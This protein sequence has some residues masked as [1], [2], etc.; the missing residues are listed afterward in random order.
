MTKTWTP[1]RIRAL[2]VITDLVTAGRIL[3]LSRNVAYHLARTGTFPV[4]V[5]QTGRFYRVHTS[6]LLTHLGYAPEP[7]GLDDHTT[8]SVDASPATNTN[9]G[10]S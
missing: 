7:R 8:R 4:P 5:R 9:R 1:S 10:Y 6:D 3:G 2:G